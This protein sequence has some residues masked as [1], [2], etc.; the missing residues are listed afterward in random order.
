MKLTP[1]KLITEIELP[2]IEGEKFSIKKI[3]GKRTLLT[4]YRF[5]TCPFCNL[6]I[7][8]ITERYNELGENFEIIAIFNS[9]QDYL[10]KVMEKHTAPFT[11]LADE[12]FEYFSKYEVEKSLIKFLIGSIVGF[13]RILKASSKGYFP[14]ELKGMTIVP[15]DVLINETGVIEKVYYGKNTTDHMS[16][17][18]IKNFSLSK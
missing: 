1:G 17:D 16:F 2:S 15:V 10:A 14:M 6:R 11:I 13:L 5:A 3:K 9:S 7:H 8:E 18:E 4:F 12:N